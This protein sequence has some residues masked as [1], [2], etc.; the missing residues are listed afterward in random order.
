MDLS[1]LLAAGFQMLTI[2]LSAENPAVSA[3]AAPPPASP[4]LL[5]CLP[6]LAAIFCQIML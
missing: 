3:R 6:L 2:T 5:G 4:V 1:A